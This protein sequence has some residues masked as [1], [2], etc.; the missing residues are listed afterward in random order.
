[1][2]ADEVHTSMSERHQELLTQLEHNLNTYL[3]MKTTIDSITPHI[4]KIHEAI[5]KLN[6]CHD[7]PADDVAPQQVKNN[8]WPH[9]R[10]ET[11]FH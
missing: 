3:D 8:Q 4:P 5:Q 9:V 7:A 2:S 1:M 10:F 11:N 6:H